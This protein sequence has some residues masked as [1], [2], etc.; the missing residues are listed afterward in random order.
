MDH[1]GNSIDGA[2]DFVQATAQPQ[3]HVQDINRAFYDNLV[4]QADDEVV[5]GLYTAPVVTADNRIVVDTLDDLGSLIR[6][7]GARGGVKIPETYISDAALHE[8]QHGSALRLLGLAVVR[9][10]VAIVDGT[11]P[12]T[13]TIQPF[14]SGEGPG[15]AITKLAFAAINAIPSVPSDGDR[16]IIRRIGYGEIP[17]LARRIVAHNRR[18]SN[19]HR[20]LLVPYSSSLA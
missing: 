19:R 9:Y 13:H 11:E 5:N 20:P 17:D 7:I 18:R 15:R 2:L 8:G 3:P 4:L 12:G 10:G 6:A 14:Y 16:E 1:L